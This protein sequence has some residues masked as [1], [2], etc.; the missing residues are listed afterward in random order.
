MGLQQ[1]KAFAQK[2]MLLAGLIMLS[3]ASFSGV[4]IKAGPCIHLRTPSRCTNYPATM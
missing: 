3:E 1:E 4:E 2:I